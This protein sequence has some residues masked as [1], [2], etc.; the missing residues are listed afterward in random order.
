MGAALFWFAGSAESW[1][2]AGGWWKV[3]MLSLL[4]AGGSS[5][6]FGT[7]FLLGMRVSDLR[8]RPPA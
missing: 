2:T 1:V 7:L 4:V 5:V 3:G 8:G 6:Y